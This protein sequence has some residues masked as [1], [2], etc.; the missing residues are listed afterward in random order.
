MAIEYVN[1]F[2]EQNKFEEEIKWCNLSWQN[3]TMILQVLPA[4]LI[5]KALVVFSL[6]WASVKKNRV[7]K[8]QIFFKWF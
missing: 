1:N 8:Q 2:G 7:M 3:T 4:W 6:G 5:L